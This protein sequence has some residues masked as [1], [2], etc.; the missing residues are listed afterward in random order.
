MAYRRAWQR[1]FD[2]SIRENPDWPV[3]VSQGDSW[4][5]YP[6]EK[7]VMDFL[8]APLPGR[9]KPD[10]KGEAAL[11]RDWSLLRLERTQDDILGVM[12]GGERAF[13]NEILQRY[14]VDALLFSAGGNDLLGPDLGALLEPYR[15]GIAAAEALV[16]KRLARRLRQIEDCYRELIDMVLDDGP[17]LKVL[18]NSYDL[19]VSSCEEARLLGGRSVGPWLRP[20][21]AA[22]GYPA[23]SPLE[24]E[25]PRLL[26]DRFCAVLDTL[27]GEVPTRFHRVETRGAVGSEWADEIHPNARG[28]RA[29]AERFE[30]VLQRFAL[31]PV[32]PVAPTAPTAPIEVAR[33]SQLRGVRKAS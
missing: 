31:V 24:R 15:S 14:A 5:S 26:L 25:I 32:V 18:V 4:F 33:P 13:L 6:H 22:K 30:Q 8:D 28:A 9:D 20:A 17:D 19:P 3:V 27:T 10:K 7:N 11:Q 2:R 29:V 12:T 16:E 23:G 1:D 21:F